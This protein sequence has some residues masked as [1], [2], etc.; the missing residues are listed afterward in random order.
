M[1]VHGCSV[2]HQYVHVLSKGWEIVDGLL[3][4]CLL[5]NKFQLKDQTMVLN[6]PQ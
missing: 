4:R 3:H 5:L 6:E 1:V 2:S